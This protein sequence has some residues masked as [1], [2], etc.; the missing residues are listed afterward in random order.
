[1]PTTKGKYCLLTKY[2]EDLI[3]LRRFIDDLFGIWIGT[4]ERWKEFVADLGFGRLTW[5]S[6]SPRDSVDFL[7]LTITIKKNEITTRTFQ[8]AMN[9][10]LYI[11]SKSAHPEGMM[12]GVI[13]SLIKR[14]KF[15]NSERK[16]YVEIVQLLYRRL[17]ARG[18]DTEYLKKTIL[19]A[20]NQ[21]NS[22]QAIPAR[23]RE[24][25]S[26]NTAILHIQYHP[27]D[28]PRRTIRDIFE[29]NCKILENYKTDSGEMMNIDNFIIAYSRAKNLKDMLT[30]SKLHQATGKEV[31]TRFLGRTS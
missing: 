21:A 13:T 16:D 8:K 11:P 28:I 25:N 2:K 15:Q 7:D 22:H 18:W 26:N 30:S 9:L 24:T 1:M 5:T 6:I 10:Y 17:A 4:D 12:K 14:F 20:V 29:K 3:F 31:S 27:N 23:K 19:S